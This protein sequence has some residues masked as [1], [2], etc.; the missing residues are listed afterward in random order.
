VKKFA[1]HLVFKT[2]YE[3]IKRK[4]MPQLAFGD[5]DKMREILDENGVLYT[6]ERIPVKELSPVQED[7]DAEILEKKVKEVKEENSVKYTI[8]S[9]D[10]AILDGHHTSA[11][12]AKVH[13]PDFKIPVFRIHLPKTSALAM[14]TDVTK[15]LDEDEEDRRVIAIYPGRFQPFHKGHYGVYKHLVDRFGK[16]NVF[17]A[18][19]DKTEGKRSPFN[20]NQ[21]KRIITSLFDVPNDHVVQ[22]R[23]P[24]APEEVLNQ[25]DPENTTMVV[26]VSEKDRGRTKG[27]ESGQYYSEWTGEDLVGY[28]EGGFYYVTPM[29]GFR[30]RGDE[31]S[32]SKIRQVFRSEEVSDEAKREFFKKLYGQFHPKV[33]DLLTRKLTESLLPKGLIERFVS[34]GRV[35]KVIKE[36]RIRF[37]L[38]EATNSG[39]SASGFNLVDDGPTTWHPDPESYRQDIDPIVNKLGYEVVDYLLDDTEGEYPGLKDDGVAIVS[40]YPQGYDPDSPVSDPNQFYMNYV[41]ALVS[42]LG[43]E[44]INYLG[45]DD[46]ENIKSLGLEDNI[47]TPL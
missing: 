7:L 30:F 17:I 26:A 45:A 47:A 5:T 44:I 2:L 15:R 43:M 18:T 6:V 46:A 16:N 19:S 10:Y 20:F 9:E 8:V 37:S 25:F 23:V 3:E 36:T 34:D 4:D 42:G 38:N 21:K 11:A 14:F 35:Q 28:D 24:Y 41:Q 40:M 27:F 13:G 22:V 33:Y 29:T 1:E 39:T 12:V 32:G 31:V